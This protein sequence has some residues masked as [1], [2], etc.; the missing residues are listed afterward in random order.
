[1]GCKMLAKFFPAAAL[2]V[3]HLLSP[4]RQHLVGV[5]ISRDFSLNA[6]RSRGKFAGLWVMIRLVGA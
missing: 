4:D 1:M 3:D 2:D 6:T 5:R